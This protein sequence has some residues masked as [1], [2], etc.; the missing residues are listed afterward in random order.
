MQ[1]GHMVMP[2]KLI[3]V[4]IS[5][6]TWILNHFTIYLKLVLG[7]PKSL[8]GFFCKMLW[9]LWMNFLVNPIV[10]ECVCVCVCVCAH[11]RACSCSD[12]HSYPTLWDPMD[13][14]LPGSSVCGIILGKNTGVSCYFL[15]QG[16]FLTQGSNL[17]L[18]QAPNPPELAGR[19]TTTTT[20]PPGKPT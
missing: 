18:T 20:E 2:F 11:V 6:Y 16:I 17:I 19:F 12:T 1:C 14:N 5:Q 9:K 3:M 4:I 7:W 8:F 15:F 10:C 13:C